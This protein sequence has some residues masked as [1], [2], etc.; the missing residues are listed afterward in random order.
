MSAGVVIFITLNRLMEEIPEHCVDGRSLLQVIGVPGGNFGEFVM[1]MTALSKIYPGLLRRLQNEDA[2]FE[3]QEKY[4]RLTG[5]Y[6]KHTDS[7]ALAALEDRLDLDGWFDGWRS[8]ISTSTE[9]W[10]GSSSLIEILIKEPPKDLQEALLWYLILPE[11]VGCGHIRCLIQNSEEYGID[12][13]FLRNAIRTFFRI[14]W[15]GSD[16]GSEISY[17]VLQGHHNEGFVMSITNREADQEKITRDSLV[18]LL[19]PRLFGDNLD[20]A[21]VWNPETV[22]AQRRLIEEVLPEAIGFSGVDVERLGVEVDETSQKWLGLTLQKLNR[23]S[24]PL[25]VYNVHITNLGDKVV[26]VQVDLST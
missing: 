25:P 11:Y 22:A 18:A 4:I 10:R 26:D 14:L 1:T 5:A 7:E 3:I 9:G 15:S 16:V 17:E 21:F 6:Y 12:P 2:V 8:R 13:E 24:E 20:S 19:P 23:G